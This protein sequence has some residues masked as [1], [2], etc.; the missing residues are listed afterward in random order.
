[1]LN[2]FTEIAL[3]DVVDLWG[4]RFFNALAVL[5]HPK[6]LVVVAAGNPNMDTVGIHVDDQ[7]RNRI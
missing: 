2:E 5:V 1:M 7:L 4:W 3:I 6:L